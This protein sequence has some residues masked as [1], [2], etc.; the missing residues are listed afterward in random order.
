MKVSKQEIF[1]ALTLYHKN[2]WKN[3]QWRGKGIQIGG[4]DWYLFRHDYSN[5]ILYKTDKDYDISKNFNRDFP[6]LGRYKDKVNV[7]FNFK[8]DEVNTVK[9]R[10]GFSNSLNLLGVA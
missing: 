9:K 1:D 5:L 7:C 10:K 3:G 6:I 8:L 2:D 4:S